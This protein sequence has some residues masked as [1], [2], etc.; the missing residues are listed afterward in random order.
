[1]TEQKKFEN[2]REFAEN[3]AELATIALQEIELEIENGHVGIDSDDDPFVTGVEHS[4]AKLINAV[5]TYGRDNELRLSM[6]RQSI[7]DNGT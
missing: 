3:F 5:A 4:L 7:I 1:M 2:A 6:A